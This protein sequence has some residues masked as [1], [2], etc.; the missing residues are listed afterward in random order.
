MPTHHE[1]AKSFGTAARPPIVALSLNH[2]RFGGSPLIRR[3]RRQSARVFGGI[4]A[5]R[6]QMYAHA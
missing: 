4:S 3:L 1:T 2:L 5:A 6:V